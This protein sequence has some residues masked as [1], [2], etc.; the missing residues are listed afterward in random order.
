MPDKFQ[1]RK[2]KSV[3]LMGRHYYTLKKD[4]KELI[5]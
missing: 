3:F 1:L 2:R 4:E 5:S